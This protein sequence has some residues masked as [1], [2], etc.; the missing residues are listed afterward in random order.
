VPQLV[1][2]FAIEMGMLPLTGT[3]DRAHMQEDLASVDI[4]ISAEDVAAI[5]GIGAVR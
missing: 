2:R 1:F 5:A 4:D 3:S